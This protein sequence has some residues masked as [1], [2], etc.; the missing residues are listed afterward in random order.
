MSAMPF[1]TDLSMRDARTAP[2]TPIFPD[3]I[4][5]KIAQAS[6]SCTRD[7]FHTWLDIRRVS[8]LFR[9]EIEGAFKRRYVRNME[10]PYTDVVDF[11]F[12]PRQELPKSLVLHRFDPSN[13]DIAIITD[14]TEPRATKKRED[15]EGRLLHRVSRALS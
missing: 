4:L 14:P 8:R 1:S 10:I 11:R 7:D 12:G 13:P 15:R 9:H 2:S 5:I 6:V 3:E